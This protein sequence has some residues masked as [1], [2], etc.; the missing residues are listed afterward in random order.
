[1][2]KDI[3]EAGLQ[4]RAFSFVYFMGQDDSGTGYTPE[5]IIIFLR[6]AVVD[7]DTLHIAFLQFPDKVFQSDSGTIG[8]NDYC[9]GIHSFHLLFLLIKGC[10]QKEKE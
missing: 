5:Y 10:R 3:P 4:S 8:R 9:I 7:H 6:R 2:L 1:M